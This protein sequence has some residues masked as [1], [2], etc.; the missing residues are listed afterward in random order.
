MRA[1]GV[2]PSAFALAADMRTTAEP[3]S[4]SV[5]A[6]AALMVPPASAFLKDGFSD[7]ICSYTQ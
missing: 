4:L 6:L 2:T 3:P 5:E 1:S 7:G